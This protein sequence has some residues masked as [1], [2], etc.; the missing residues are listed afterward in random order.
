MKIDSLKKQE[1]EKDKK[2]FELFENVSILTNQIKKAEILSSGMKD[3]LEK[4]KK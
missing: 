3:E 4:N 2:I 1:K